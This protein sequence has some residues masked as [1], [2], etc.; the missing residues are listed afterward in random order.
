MEAFAPGLTK[1]SRL[2]AIVNA[3]PCDS[4]SFQ[5]NKF[6]EKLLGSLNPW[7]AS[8]LIT[9]NSIIVVGITR[10]LNAEEPTDP[11][12]SDITLTNI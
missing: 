4:D 8:R 10:W 1:T 2:A 5:T 6:C 3:K 7:M 9:R 11:T 12:T